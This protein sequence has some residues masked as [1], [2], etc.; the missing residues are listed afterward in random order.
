MIKKG[1]ILA[2]LLLL[3]T[4]IKPVMAQDKVVDEIVAVCVNLCQVVV[5]V[6]FAFTGVASPV[7]VP[8]M[9]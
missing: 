6:T 7:H 4:A 8:V 3:A 1:F 9:F 2:L 5:K